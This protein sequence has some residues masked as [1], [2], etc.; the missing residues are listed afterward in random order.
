MILNQ[1]VVLTCPISNC[2]YFGKLEKWRASIEHVLYRKCTEQKKCILSEDQHISLIVNFVV[3]IASLY[4]GKFSKLVT[5]VVFQILL[6]SSHS[7]LE[8]HISKIFWFR[9]LRN[10]PPSI[11]LRNPNPYDSFCRNQKLPHSLCSVKERLDF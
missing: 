9:S 4:C 7:C 6:S 1:D 3:I 11:S 2:K 5:I 10:I 8:I